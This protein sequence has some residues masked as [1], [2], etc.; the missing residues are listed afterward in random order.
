MDKK[1]QDKTSKQ[2][3]TRALAFANALWLPTKASQPHLDINDRRV[4]HL[5]SCGVTDVAHGAHKPLSGGTYRIHY[6]IE[7]ARTPDLISKRALCDGVCVGICDGVVYPLAG[8]VPGSTVDTGLGPTRA[9]GSAWREHGRTLAWGL[10]LATG[11]LVS[12]T[13][14]DRAGAFDGCTRQQLLP[15]A[16]ERPAYEGEADYGASRTVC[17]EVTLSDEAHREHDLHFHRH[18][19]DNYSLHPLSSRKRRDERRAASSGALASAA[20]VTLARVA[21]S[22][23]YASTGRLCERRRV[24]A[25]HRPGGRGALR[26]A[27]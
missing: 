1:T 4:T 11:Q 7:P 17:V 13:N 6:L 21:R 2:Q 8:S 27:A 5:R 9:A 19:H 23:G 12:S 15:R 18:N 3:D 22:V 14:L 10:D 26:A 16:R 24:R 25:T 20:L